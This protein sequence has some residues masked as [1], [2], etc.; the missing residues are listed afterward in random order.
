[1]SMS[2]RHKARGFEA[3]LSPSSPRA[4]AATPRRVAS[5]S[6]KSL[7]R[8]GTASLAPFWAKSITAVFLMKT[9]TLSRSLS[10]AGTSLFSFLRF[11]MDVFRPGVSW[12]LWLVSWGVGVVGDGGGKDEEGPGRHGQKF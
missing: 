1:M 10:R 5:L 8:S 4:Q 2:L 11:T 12:L 9:E 7:S 6:F 3:R